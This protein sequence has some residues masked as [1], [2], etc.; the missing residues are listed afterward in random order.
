MRERVLGDEVLAPHLGRIHADLGGVEIH[1]PLDRLC[2]LGSSSASE[3]RHRRRVRDHRAALD[4]DPVDVVDAGREHRGERRHEGPDSGVGA[5]VLRDVELVG[6]HLAVPRP[7]QRHVEPLPAAVSERVHALG[8]RLRPA[9][10]DAVV[11]RQPDDERLLGAERGLRA[12]A[13]SDVGRDDPQLVR[14]EPERRAEA[15]VVPVRHLRREPGGDLAVRRL[16]CGRAHLERACGHALADERVRHDDVAALEQRRVVIHAA[17]PA[18][19]VRPDVRE[20]QQLVLCGLLRVEE[21]RQ[22]LVLDGDEL[23]GVHAGCAVVAEDDGHDVTDEAHDLLR[24]ERPPQPLLEHGDRRRRPSTR[25][26]RRRR[27]GPRCSGA[28]LRPRRRSR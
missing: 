18:R 12:E 2:R 10:R 8:A 23:G 24:D 21:H 11:L 6:E 15:V 7:A 16:G 1:H 26:R 19:D 28:P 25:R 13:A 22:R 14:I 4:F 27:S 5:R 17:R 9:H 20:E 3:R